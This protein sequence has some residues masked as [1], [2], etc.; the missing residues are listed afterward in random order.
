MKNMAEQEPKKG[1]ARGRGRKKL[2]AL[3]Y[4]HIRIPTVL[5]KRFQER[6]AMEGRS[7]TGWLR[8]VLTKELRRR[9]SLV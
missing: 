5:Y 4:A 7:F 2:P 6:A 3:S 1:E 9:K 8:V